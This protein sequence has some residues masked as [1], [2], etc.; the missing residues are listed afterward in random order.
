[1]GGWIILAILAAL[2]FFAITIY[3]RLVAS[4]NRFKNAFAQIDVQLKRRHDL[5]PN[6]VATVMDYAKHDRDVLERVTEGGLAAFEV[7]KQ[8]WPQVVGD[9]LRDRSRPVRLSRGVLTVEVS[10]GGTASRLRL[11]QRRI[12]GELETALG[13]GAVAQIRWRVQ[14][15]NHRENDS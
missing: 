7:I 13:R 5:I 1:M 4:R 15:R 8:T 12:R 10:D 2:V 11:E 14:R 6:L 9:E 3:N